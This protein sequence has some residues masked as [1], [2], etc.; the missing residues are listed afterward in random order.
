[1]QLLGHGRELVDDLLDVLQQAM[2]R[3]AAITS[4]GIGPEGVIGL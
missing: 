3:S 1:V 4:G 2:R